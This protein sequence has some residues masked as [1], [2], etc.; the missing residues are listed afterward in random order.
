ML[1]RFSHP[2]AY[3]ND[4]KVDECA[5]FEP[6]AL[7]E[8]LS[9][10]SSPYMVSG[11]KIMWCIWSVS[12]YGTQVYKL[13]RINIRHAQVTT[14]HILRNSFFACYRLL[15][16]LFMRVKD[17]NMPHVQVT[18]LNRFETY[19]SQIPILVLKFVAFTDS[20]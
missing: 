13:H 12:C 17:I 11:I 7:A 8:R 16:M 20:I 18:H 1:P 19:L 2:I 9:T 3:K 4:N 6:L 14:R 5:T 10:V 15:H